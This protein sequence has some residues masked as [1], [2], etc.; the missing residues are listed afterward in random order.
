MTGKGALGSVSEMPMETREIHCQP[1]KNAYYVQSWVRATA[2]DSTETLPLIT[3]SKQAFSFL[4]GSILIKR[5][6]KHKL[7]SN[8]ET[9]ESKRI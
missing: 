2:Q 9:Q 7:P 6:G 8:S 3:A 4:T 5:W 1:K